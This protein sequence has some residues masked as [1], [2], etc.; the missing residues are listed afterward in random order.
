MNSLRRVLPVVP[1]LDEEQAARLTRP[2]RWIAMLGCV[3]VPA[4]LL[5][6]TQIGARPGIETLIGVH[7][8]ILL[9][10][11][12]GCL[13]SL[14]LMW[15]GHSRAGGVL[16]L[17]AMWLG[18][19]LMPDLLGLP[20]H[21]ISANHVALAMCM[22]PLL[23]WTGSFT[24]GVGSL[25]YVLVQDSQF[26]LGYGVGPLLPASPPQ[27]FVIEV[28]LYG[29]LVSLTVLIVFF[30]QRRSEISQVTAEALE[31][32]SY[33][34]KRLE[35][36]IESMADVLLVVDTRGA[37]VKANRA[38][39]TLLGYTESELSGKPLRTLLLDIPDEASGVETMSK[40]AAMRQVNRRLKGK[41]GRVVPVSLSSAVMTDN[42]GYPAGIILVA[43]DMT[44]LEAIRSELH[45]S[46]VRF[47]Q[48]V[49]FS[50]IGV[51]EYDMDTHEFFIED[52][53]RRAL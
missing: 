37:I 6:Y 29:L 46:N 15:K 25:I 27:V 28:A 16:Q 31:V 26:G 40:R 53:P 49:A 50:R 43:Q 45:R 7:R 17:A 41:D 48:A 14:T 20:L 24:V 1:P 8:L 44:E 2:L 39:F 11:L 23:G 47:N 21:V 19:T 22:G 35:T 30:S 10:V 18:L 33:S 38:A 36:I 12:G 9:V 42:A 32:A 51:F 5:V 34:E 13:A 52:A 3:V 4:L